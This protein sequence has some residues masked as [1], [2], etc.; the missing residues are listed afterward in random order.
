MDAQTAAGIAVLVPRLS[1][2]CSGCM[3]GIYLAG[4]LLTGWTAH[5]LRDAVGLLPHGVCEVPAMIMSAAVGICIAEPL[6]AA[7]RGG[8]RRVRDC[9]VQLLTSPRLLRLLALLIAVIA[10]G[11]AIEVRTM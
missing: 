3:I 6:V 5:L 1:V 8:V 9:A 4:A 7:A 2:A 10:I 11:G